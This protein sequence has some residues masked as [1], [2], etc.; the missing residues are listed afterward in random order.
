MWMDPLEVQDCS[1]DS[2]EEKGGERYV[3]TEEIVARRLK[4]HQ[5]LQMCWKL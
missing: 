1:V 4:L 5:R 2:A 3:C